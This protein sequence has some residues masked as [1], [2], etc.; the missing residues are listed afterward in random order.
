MWL[1][2]CRSCVC[3]MCVY[4]HTRDGKSAALLNVFSLS[5][6][7][8]ENLL[9]EISPLGILGLQRASCLD[10]REV[11]PLVNRGFPAFCWLKYFS[12]GNNEGF[13]FLELFGGCWCVAAGLGCLNPALV[14][15]MGTNP[16][17][18]SWLQEI[19]NN[20]GERYRVLK[21]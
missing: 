16:V 9:P 19:R 10:N 6:P 12:M 17:L 2:P 14:F 1:F 21:H 15:R 8:L 18:V 7:P 20:E 11:H 13:S 4:L 5:L 3:C